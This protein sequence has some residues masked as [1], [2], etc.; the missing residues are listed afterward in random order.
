MKLLLPFLSFLLVTASGNAATKAKTPEVTLD[1]A[2]S[3][4]CPEQR[5]Q[6]ATMGAYEQPLETSAHGL[7]AAQNEALEASARQSCSGV[8]LG[9][10]C[11]NRGRIRYLA[12]I[13][14][15][16]VMIQAFCA[17]KPDTFD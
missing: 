2:L 14:R 17:I 5:W 8:P 15:M 7:S 4:R 10:W 13:G 12:T 6:H 9:E 11:D 16:T 1:Q 3:Q